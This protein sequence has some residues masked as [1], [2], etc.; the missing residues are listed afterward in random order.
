[1]DA[2]HTLVGRREWGGEWRGRGDLLICVRKETVQ[3]PE[4]PSIPTT[5]P[6]PF[7][8]DNFIYLDGEN[9]LFFFKR[10]VYL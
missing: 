8:R 3:R 6:T 2:L 4:H 10:Q 1:M 7:V 5:I 9:T